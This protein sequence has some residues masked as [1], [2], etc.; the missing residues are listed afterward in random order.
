MGA[1]K[2]HNKKSNE[3]HE[4]KRVGTWISLSVVAGV[5]LLTYLTLYGLFMARV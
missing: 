4:E 3:A 2:V 1:S 5:I